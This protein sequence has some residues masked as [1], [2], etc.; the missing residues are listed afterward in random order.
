MYVRARATLR[1]HKHVPC[2]ARI[3][4]YERHKNTRG[5]GS[6]AGSHSLPLRE[7]SRGCTGYTMLRVRDFKR[8]ELYFWD[9]WVWWRRV[10]VRRRSF[11][12]LFFFGSHE[13]FICGGVVLTKM[14][15]I[16]FNKMFLISSFVIIKIQK[17]KTEC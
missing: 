3:C 14:G 9:L 2:S 10:E 11:C 1:T 12:W 17:L 13:I 5:A 8:P 6:S 4:C 7:F 16:F 15:L